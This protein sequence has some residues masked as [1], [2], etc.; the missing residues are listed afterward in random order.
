MTPTRRAS[1]PLGLLAITFF[2]PM[3]DACNEVV[4]PLSYIR[5]GN[6]ATALWLA[7]TFATAAILTA[8]IWRSRSGAPKTAA[9]FVATTALVITLPVLAIL[10]LSDSGWLQAPLYAG[11]SVAS[12]LLL[13]RA[14]RAQPAEKLSAL[15]D[16]YVVAVLPLAVAILSVAK[17]FGAHIFLAAYATL[18][19]QRVFSLVQRAIA[20]RGGAA[21][22]A[23][24]RV[25]GDIADWVSSQT[26]VQEDLARFDEAL[27]DY[28]AE[29]SEPVL[30]ARSGGGSSA[31]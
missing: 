11:A 28:V 13:R 19:A 6:F 17:Y 22:S 2:L 10:F 16:V 25:A 24:V 12:W 7:P 20:T 1:I 30:R 15:L 23:R 21:T 31:R 27:D 14:R 18:A 26:R 4:S 5:S 9:A 3:A 8:A 29:H